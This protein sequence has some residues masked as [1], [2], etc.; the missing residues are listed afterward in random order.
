MYYEIVHMS[1]R[2]TTQGFKARHA[3]FKKVH[4]VMKLNVENAHRL[5]E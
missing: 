1:E 2:D 3:G 4:D 5:Q